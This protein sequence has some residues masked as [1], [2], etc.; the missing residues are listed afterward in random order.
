MFGR[1]F[2]LCSLLVALALLT[3]VLG[4]CLAEHDCVS[5]ETGGMSRLVHKVRVWLGWEPD[6][7]LDHV[8]D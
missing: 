3:P 8:C 1:R 2:V 6:S 7:P 5:A 4:A